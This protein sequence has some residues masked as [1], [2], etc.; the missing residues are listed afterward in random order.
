M[1]RISF[2]EDAWDEYTKWQ[3]EDKAISIKLNKLLKEIRRNPTKGVGKPELLKHDLAGFWSRRID[4]EHR[5]VY[6]VLDD[7]IR[8]VSCRYHY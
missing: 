4:Q 8:V 7:E 2:S 3:R 5:I 6:R 1:M